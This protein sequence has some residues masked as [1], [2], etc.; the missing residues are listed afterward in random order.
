MGEVPGQLQTETR[1]VA[2]YVDAPGVSMAIPALIVDA[3]ERAARASLEFFTARIPNAHT[4]RAYGRAVGAFCHWCQGNRITR[5]G[6]T[7]P[8]VSAYLE[9]LRD[10]G[11]GLSLFAS[12]DAEAEL[13]AMPTRASRASTSANRASSRKRKS[14]GS[15]CERNR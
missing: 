14:K 9:G 7:A 3:G 2:L 4:R 10:G 5:A 13:A 6:L 11:E 8:T 12:L 15:S 1:A